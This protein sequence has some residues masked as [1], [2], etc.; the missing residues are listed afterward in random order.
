ME[1][2]W[3]AFIERYKDKIPYTTLSMML[4]AYYYFIAG[5]TEK[6]DDIMSKL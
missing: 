2:Y 1:T 6:S 4:E 5:K 3:N